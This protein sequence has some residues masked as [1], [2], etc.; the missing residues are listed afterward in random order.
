[1]TAPDN[2]AERP[3]SSAGS[4]DAA[5]GT[6][7]ASSSGGAEAAGPVRRRRVGLL[8]RWGAIA[9]VV[10]LVG[11]LGYL[12]FDSR[13]PSTYSVM[14]MGYADYGGGAVPVGGHQHASGTSVATLT[15]P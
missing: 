12:W 1:M 3:D 2:P 5:L 9:L 8:L 11:T 15:G 7:V 4:D 6:L 10:V 13:L 14:D